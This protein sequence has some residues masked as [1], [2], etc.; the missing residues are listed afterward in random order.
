[1]LHQCLIVK[2]VFNII[3]IVLSTAAKKNPIKEVLKNSNSKHVIHARIINESRIPHYNKNL[4]QK[5][6]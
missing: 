5:I 4:S 2:R 1:M 6:I 3:F